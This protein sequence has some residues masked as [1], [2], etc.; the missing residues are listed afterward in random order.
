MPVKRVLKSV[1]FLLIKIM[2]K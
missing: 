1:D 2:A